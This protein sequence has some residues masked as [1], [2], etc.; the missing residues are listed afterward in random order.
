MSLIA[1]EN[2]FGVSDQ[3]KHKPGHKD[4]IVDSLKD[5]GP[6]VRNIVSLTTLLRCQLIKYANYIIKY[7][8]IF[9]CKNVRIFC[10]SKDSHIFSTKN[11]NL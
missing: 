10:T 1:R 3:V 6:V 11:S 4:K 5:Q 7:T 8:G 9:C 2:T